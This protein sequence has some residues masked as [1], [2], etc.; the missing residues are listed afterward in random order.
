M[1]AVTAWRPSRRLSVHALWALWTTCLLAT[2]L[3]HV[4]Q[5][6]ALPDVVI[7]RLSSVVA[8]V[9]LVLVW[10][11]AT[12]RPGRLLRVAATALLWAALSVPTLLLVGLSL[13]QTAREC[14]ATLVQ[15]VVAL[16][17]YRWRIGD[18]NLAPHRPGDVAALF[19]STLLGTVAA[20]PLL[21]G[22]TAV[23]TGQAQ[24]LSVASWLL[25]G[26]S[27][28]FIGAACLLLLVQRRPRAEAVPT[29]LPDVYLLLLAT[30]AAVALEVSFP[31]LSLS[32]L[33]LLP[34]V[35][36]GLL[37]G[38]WATA[39]YSLVTAVTVLAAT[40]AQVALGM[41]PLD[42]D[43]LLDN[44]LMAAFVLVALLLSQVRDQ[45]A[46][47]SHEVVRRRQEAVD[48]AG[49][50]ETLLD[51]IDEALVLVD[52][53]GRVQLH[54]PAAARLLG[55][56]RLLSEPRK[57]LRGPGELPIRFSYTFHR[58]PGDDATRILAV[59]L[60][61]VQYAGA[62]GVVAVA[63]DVTHEHRRIEELASFAAVAAH[64]LKSPLAAVQGW[65]EVAEEVVGTDHVRTRHAVRRGR[66]AARRMVAEIDD[67][68]AY[69]VAREGELHPERVALEPVLHEI[70]ASHQDADFRF[71][72]EHVVLADRVL[73]RHLLSN[74]VGNAVKYTRA[75][76]RASVHVS[77]SLDDSGWVRL[78]VVD[79]GIGIPAGEELAVFEPFRRAS[80]VDSYQGSG[81]GLALCKRIVRRHGGS[82]SA[83]RNDSGPGTEIAVT[84]PADRT[85]AV[86]AEAAAAEP[87]EESEQVRQLEELERENPG[88]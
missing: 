24:S 49:L 41:R 35:W 66:S 36:A 38:P 72:V 62:D 75:G 40:S 10:V 27:H 13:E 69:T 81:L 47:L 12:G 2:P 31:A 34:A 86:V 3:T 17:C 23:L 43:L 32:W 77:S 15:V 1:E 79:A 18:D 58:G 16:A 59:Q 53:S 83:R 42:L 4:V 55:D 67:W 87:A 45:R 73:L 21:P 28:T 88:A 6:A 82:I 52:P 84:L 68:L 8:F 50:L 11:W 46:H 80:T 64:D 74:L 19:V 29:R 25:T 33:V 63:R 7:L 30:G 54:N 22:G 48:Q 20:T 9:W 39:A 76:E 51:S 70:A 60:A 37:M 61:A 56:E 78:L 14:A 85:Q 71:E 57:W 44:C 5:Q 65:L 26:A